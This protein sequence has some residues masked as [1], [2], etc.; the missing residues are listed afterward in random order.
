MSRDRK[1]AVLFLRFSNGRKRPP[2]GGQL[3]VLCHLYF[4]E[5]DALAGTQS[6]LLP[7]LRDSV[8][9]W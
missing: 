1:G 5:D 6:A 8:P 7:S 9:L 2:E 3:R 4:G